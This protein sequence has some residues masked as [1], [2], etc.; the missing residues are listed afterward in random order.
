MEF[1]S[2][3]LAKDTELYIE[4]RTVIIHQGVFSKGT[5]LKTLL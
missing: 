5:F 4:V 3:S 1:F 2:R